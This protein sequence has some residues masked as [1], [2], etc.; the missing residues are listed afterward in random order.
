VYVVLDGSRRAVAEVAKPRGDQR[1]LALAPGDYVV[2]KRD[3]ETC[4]SAASASPTRQSRSPMRGSR[5]GR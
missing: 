4:W 1:R 5:G 2:K 3:G